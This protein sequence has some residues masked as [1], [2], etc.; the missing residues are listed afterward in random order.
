[1]EQERLSRAG[2][3]AAAAVRGEVLGVVQDVL[4][5]QDGARGE[6]V[7][8]AEVEAGGLLDVRGGRS[9]YGRGRGGVGQPRHPALQGGRPPCSGKGGRPPMKI[10]DAAGRE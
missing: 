9:V 6:V 5:R 7:L 3:A 1:A 10:T 2:H 8:L 4:V